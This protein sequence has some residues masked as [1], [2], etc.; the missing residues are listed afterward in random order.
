MKM[1]G[2][3]SLPGSIDRVWAALNDVEVLREAIPGCVELNQVSSSSMDAVIEI[4][5]G[6][7][8]A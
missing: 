2:E 5:A 6:P 1:Q 3:Q 4:K 8:K 7:I